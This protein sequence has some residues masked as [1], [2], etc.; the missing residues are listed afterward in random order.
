MD[1]VSRFGTSISMLCPPILL[2]S[3]NSKC[4]NSGDASSL[5]L[6]IAI[7]Q[8]L[9][10]TRRL[11]KGQPNIFVS[12]VPP[13]TWTCSRVSE[14][15]LLNRTLSTGLSLHLLRCNSSRDSKTADGRTANIGIHLW[16]R[17]VIGRESGLDKWRWSLYP[18]RERST[19]ETKFCCEE[20]RLGRVDPLRRH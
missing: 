11:S 13:S 12:K 19:T 3:H 18:C 17:E 14:R 10:I 16:G 8:Q 20:S 7:S 5:T 1:N 15:K 6:T 4:L 9:L 2:E